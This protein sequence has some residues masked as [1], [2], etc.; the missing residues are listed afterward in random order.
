MENI[1][2]TEPIAEEGDAEAPD[3]R[4]HRLNGA[5]TF[6]SVQDE[7][8]SQCADVRMFGEGRAELRDEP[9]RISSVA[10]SKTA[11]FNRG[12]SS[13]SARNR[14]DASMRGGPFP[15]L[16]TEASISARLR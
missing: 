14:A 8:H 4:G 9:G 10:G 1:D 2:E 6:A 16:I 13:I 15:S 12:F 11:N 7:I 5:V 3:G